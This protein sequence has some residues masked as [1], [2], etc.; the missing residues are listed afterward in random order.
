MHAFYPQYICVS[1]GGLFDKE[2]YFLLSF[3]GSPTKHMYDECA[4]LTLQASQQQGQVQAQLVAA[5]QEEKLQGRE[6]SFTNF[7]SH[8]WNWQKREMMMK[9]VVAPNLSA[10]E[11]NP[12]CLEQRRQ[13]SQVSHC[14]VRRAFPSHNISPPEQRQRIVDLAD[15]FRGPRFMH[16]YRAGCG[17]CY[18]TGF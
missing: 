15:P 12:E 13:L 4:Y 10:G 6:A 7:Y 17:C 5:L 14:Q 18:S 3:L 9:V 8:F 2:F 1:V 16:F 11:R